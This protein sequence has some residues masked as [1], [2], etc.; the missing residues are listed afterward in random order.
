MFRR[1]K[2]AINVLQRTAYDQRIRDEA[3]VVEFDVDDDG[4]VII[5]STDDD[6]STGPENITVRVPLGEEDK[7][8][9]EDEVADYETEEEGEGSTKQRRARI[10]AAWN[11][12]T[13]PVIAPLARCWMRQ[14]P[15]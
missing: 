6:D 5:M 3:N 9:D 7:D 2:E 14:R 4:D 12:R 1:T 10:R 13:H 11:P 8:E 15:R